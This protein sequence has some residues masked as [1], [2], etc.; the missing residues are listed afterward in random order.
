[1]SAVDGNRV[2]ANSQATLLGE[3]A[4]MKISGRREL[5][6][7]TRR[8]GRRCAGK[9]LRLEGSRARAYRSVTVEEYLQGMGR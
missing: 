8:L 6:P 7:K 3:V 5:E 4:F 1:M 9:A 2:T